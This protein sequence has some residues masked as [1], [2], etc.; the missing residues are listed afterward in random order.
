MEMN[1]QLALLRDRMDEREKL[2]FDS[3]RELNGDMM[4][5][6]FITMAAIRQRNFVLALLVL[7]LG[8]NAWLAV[9]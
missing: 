2:E 8:L 3:L 1:E 4:Q 5:C 6:Y 7:S 9:A